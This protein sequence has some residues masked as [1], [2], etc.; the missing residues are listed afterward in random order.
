MQSAQERVF[1]TSFIGRREEL[2]TARRLLQA[3]RLLT[4][5]GPGG[6]GKT[7]LAVE[8]AEAVSP[9]FP[10]GALSVSLAPISDPSLV[11]PTW[12]RL[13]G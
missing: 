13:S 2:L 12:R 11:L 9:G 7:R 4:L 3:D 1:L 10:D 6:V 8:L 5:V